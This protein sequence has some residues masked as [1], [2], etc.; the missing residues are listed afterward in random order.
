VI[1]FCHSSAAVFSYLPG[2]VKSASEWWD[3]INQT[4]FTAGETFNLSL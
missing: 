1:A 2:F 3:V 4:P